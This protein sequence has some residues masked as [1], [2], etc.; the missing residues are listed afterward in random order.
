MGLTCAC[1]RWAHKLA[2][3]HEGHDI[4]TDLCKVCFRSLETPQ[5][6]GPTLGYRQDNSV[7]DGVKC[8]VRRG[9]QRST[10]GRRG[11]GRCQ[12]QNQLVRAGSVLAWALARTRCRRRRTRCLVWQVRRRPRCLWCR[13]ARVRAR[14]SRA[15]SGAPPRGGGRRAAASLC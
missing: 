10:P 3:K 8:K 1:R 5:T 2:A 7:L 13:C 14:W 11:V 4:E 6:L 12:P 15:L 9:W